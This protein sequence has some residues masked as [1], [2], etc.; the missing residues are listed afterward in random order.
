MAGQTAKIV[1]IVNA[2]HELS[3]VM[4]VLESLDEGQGE[5]LLVV[6]DGAVADM[7]PARIPVK[8]LNEYTPQEDIQKKAVLWLDDWSEKPLVNGHSFKELFSYKDL[9]L[10]WFFLPVIFPDVMRCMRYIDLFSAVYTREKPTIVV[11][12]DTASRPMLPFRLNRAFDLAGRVA[13][14]MAKFE[15]VRIVTPAPNWRGH[16]DF[17]S[18]YL[19]RYSMSLFYRVLGRRLDMIC[20]SA[21]FRVSRILRG[22]TAQSDKMRRKLVLFSTPAYWRG[23]KITSA[24]PGG[25]DAIAGRVV[26]ELVD[27]MGWEVVDIDVE[28][29]VP[30]LKHY[31]RL[32]HK[33]RRPDVRC[34]PLECYYDRD[35]RASVAREAERIEGVWKR[36]SSDE[37]FP[38]SLSY[39]GVPL[40]QFL[41]QR[42]EYLLS[43]YATMALL[44][45]EAVERVIYAENPNAVLLE[46]EEGSYGRAATVAARKFGIPSIALQ[47]GLHGGAYIP[48]YYF[49]QTAWE[50]GGSMN[51]CP[52]PTKTAVFGAETHRYLTE[53]SSYPDASIAIT[54]TTIYDGVLELRAGMDPILTR[55]QLGCAER[56]S[57]AILS[58]IFTDAQDRIW[59]IENALGAVADINMQCLVKLHPREDGKDWLSVAERMGV[60]VPHIFRDQ[61]WRVIVAADVVVSWYSTTILDALLLNKPVVVLRIPGKNNPDSLA[62]SGA[63]N[64]ADNRVQLGVLLDYL[65]SD[66][67]QIYRS[68]EA[69]QQLLGDHLYKLDGGAQKRI[70]D[71]IDQSVNDITLDSPICMN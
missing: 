48:S 53:I 39:A 59:F 46:Y 22:R 5:C 65:K 54:G 67:Q 20:R 16:W 45:I 33:I 49:R 19:S 15:G 68:Q 18:S 36:L 56:Y 21:I 64:V 25:A 13:L 63:L 44:H 60:P 12:S 8:I 57:V 23:E 14:I 69:G 26:D 1:G 66:K 58:S 29:N 10:W 9:S 27:G 3:S 50:K 55:Q 11:C 62:D 24:S 42:L 38:K 17:W 4:H 41:G 34:M 61:L 31:N 70:A 30:S 43:D 28:V 37:N 7:V 2:V 40:Q 51:A 6:G 47:H 52:I 32:W 71:L 35:L